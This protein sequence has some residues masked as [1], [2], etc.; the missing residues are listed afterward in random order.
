[1]RGGIYHTLHRFLNGGARINAGCLA[2]IKL[3]S[4][5]CQS[6]CGT[7]PLLR[8]GNVCVWCLTY[9]LYIQHQIKLPRLASYV[10]NATHIHSIFA[11]DMTTVSTVARPL[12]HLRVLLWT[13]KRRGQLLSGAACSMHISTSSSVVDADLFKDASRLVII[14]TRCADRLSEILLFRVSATST[15]AAAEI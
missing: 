13:N 5:L 15:R 11:A 2:L 14:H 12:D 6:A 1:V 8:T 10:S 4:R 9:I 3:V 7:N